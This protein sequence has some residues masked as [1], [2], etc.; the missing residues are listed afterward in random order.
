MFTKYLL[1]KN[2]EAFKLNSKVIKGMQDK[3]KNIAENSKEIENY[4]YNFLL[5]IIGRL[6][7]T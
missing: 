3:N 4:L 7:D 2:D 6:D 5:L 1:N